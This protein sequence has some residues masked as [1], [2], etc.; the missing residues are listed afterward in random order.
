MS[1]V[2]RIMV[3]KWHKRFSEGRDSKEVDARSGRQP[4]EKTH[5][6]SMKRR[7]GIIAVRKLS[8]GVNV[9]IGFKFLMREINAQK[10]YFRF[11]P[12]LLRA[13]KRS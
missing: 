13:N 3:F 8:V 12:I 9:G 7:W 4:V 5:P 6:F 10:Y 1:S 2:R 11:R